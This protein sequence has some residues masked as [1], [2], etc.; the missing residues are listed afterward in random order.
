MYILLSIFT[1]ACGALSYTTYNLLRKVETLEEELETNLTIYETN[2]VDIRDQFIDA[3]TE[4]KQ[5]DINGT[6]E[7]DDEVG[8]IFKSVKAVINDLDRILKEYEKN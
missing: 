2:L 3:E 7:S 4:I 6:F 8:I 5:L 1:I